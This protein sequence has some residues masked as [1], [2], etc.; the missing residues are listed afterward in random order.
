[1]LFGRDPDK[2]TRN[3]IEDYLELSDCEFI[4]T[5]H[6]PKSVDYYSW[7]FHFSPGDLRGMSNM[8]QLQD[9]SDFDGFF[10]ADWELHVLVMFS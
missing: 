2:M 8:A 6:L 10:G 4:T 1:M 5:Q 3:R 7:Q 9:F